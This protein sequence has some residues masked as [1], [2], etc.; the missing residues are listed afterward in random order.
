MHDLRA[1]NG[2]PQASGHHKVVI[3]LVSAGGRKRGDN[4]RITHIKPP[5]IG[6]GLRRHVE[7][8]CNDPLTTKSGY[9][10]RNLREDIK[11]LGGGTLRI[12]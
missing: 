9:H 5:R 10:R 1:N 3:Y 12:T 2:V 4:D 8:A 11:V 7:V 6:K